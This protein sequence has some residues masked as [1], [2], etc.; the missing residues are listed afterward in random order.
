[1]TLGRNDILAQHPRH[2]ELQKA[3]WWLDFIKIKKC[4][5]AKDTVERIKKYATDWEKMFTED[6]CD[7]GLS[8]TI[9]KEY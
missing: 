2:D 9:Y 4:C 5:S 7:E 1:M 3:Y 8:S 6:T